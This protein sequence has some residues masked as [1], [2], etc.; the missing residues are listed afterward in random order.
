MLILFNANF[1]EGLGISLSSVFLTKNALID[2]L[3]ALTISQDYLMGNTLTVL[4]VVIAAYNIF[5][6]ELLVEVFRLCAFWGK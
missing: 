3:N 1:I 5:R 2:T 6:N 4:H